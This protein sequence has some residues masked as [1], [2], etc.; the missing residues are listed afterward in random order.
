[1]HLERFIW[2]LSC[3]RQH[4]SLNLHQ[5][6]TQPFE[7]SRTFPKDLQLLPSCHH[8]EVVTMTQSFKDLHRDCRR[9]RGT[10]FRPSW[11]SLST[12]LPMC[13]PKL[14]LHLAFHT[15]PCRVWPPCPSVRVLQE[16]MCKSTCELH[17]R[18]ALSTHPTLP[19][20]T[21]R[22]HGFHHRVLSSLLTQTSST[23]LTAAWVKIRLL[24][25]V[26]RLCPWSF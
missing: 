3:I 1:M 8:A 16:D 22:L 24:V 26:V 4:A 2:R 21:D 7:F 13:L 14:T 25:Q 18:R 19:S 10:R 6:S 17:R 12:L 11:N 9:E 5:V 15:C 20:Q 23:L